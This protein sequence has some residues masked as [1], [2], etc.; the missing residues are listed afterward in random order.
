MK[1]LGQLRKMNAEAQNPVTYFLNLDKTSYPLNPHIG[2]PMGLKW[3]GT[4]T[5]IECGRKTRKSYDFRKMP[6]V[7]FARNYVYTKKEMRPIASSGAP[8]VTSITLFT[9]R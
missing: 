9:F 5:C 2:K 1:L 7:R 3:T 4:I 8:I 6:C